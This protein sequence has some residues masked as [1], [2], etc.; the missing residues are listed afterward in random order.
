M[1]MFS[2]S[3]SEGD[4]LLAVIKLEKIGNDDEPIEQCSNQA[5]SL[6]KLIQSTSNCS[7][8]LGRVEINLD[9]D[10]DGELSQ[11]EIYG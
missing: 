6:G 5:I 7:L 9:F 1:T 2:I 11:I 8:S 10:E 3:V 4:S